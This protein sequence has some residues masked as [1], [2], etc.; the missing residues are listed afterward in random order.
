M[1]Q[2]RQK[3][4]FYRRRVCP[5][6]Q[7]DFPEAHQETVLGGEAAITDGEGAVVSRTPRGSVL[8]VV[9]ADDRSWSAYLQP[10]QD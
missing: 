1:Q 5:V 2:H 8:A 4:Q 10:S 9:T 7:I 6:P 3:A